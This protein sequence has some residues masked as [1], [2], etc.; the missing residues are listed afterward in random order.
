M[1]SRSRPCGIAFAHDLAAAQDRGAVAQ[2]F[3]LLQLVADVEDRAALGRELAE[4]L[5]QRVDLLRGQHRGRLVHDQELGALQQAADDLDPLALADREGV[6]LALGVER[7][8]VGVADLADAALP[9]PS[10][11]CRRRRRA[12]RSPARSSPRTARSAGRPCRCPDARAAL[13][14][15]TR[16]G[17]PSQSISPS[18]AWS[19]P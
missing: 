11:R 8:A 9:A 5:E 12:P 19:T 1:P 2:G 7:Q 18:S 17:L 6:D 14:S 4:G 16:T 3:D 10:C 15:A 13:G